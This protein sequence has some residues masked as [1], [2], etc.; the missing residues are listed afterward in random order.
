MHKFSPQKAERLENKER[1]ELLK[2]E[3]TLRRFGLKEGMVFADIG[4][5]T[6]FFSRAASSIVGKNGIV[7]AIDISKE[8][9]KA[10]ERFGVPQNVFLVKS[11]ESEIPLKT[12]RADFTLMAFVLHENHH[13]RNFLL[14]SARITQPGKQIVVID[15]K[16]QDEEHGPPKDE[17]LDLNELIAISGGF[18]IISSGDLNPSHY[19][20]IVQLSR[21]Y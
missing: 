9:L 6:G 15:W 17:R 14:E 2:P 4:A 13:P 8:M 20:C 7:Y 19:Y 11:N 5:G 18:K 16:K 21:E 1:Y 12:A 3:E 10:F